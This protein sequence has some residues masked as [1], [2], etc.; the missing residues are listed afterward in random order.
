M[1]MPVSIVMRKSY[2]VDQQ[3]ENIAY[4]YDGN[5]LLIVNF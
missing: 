1:Q 4:N 2:S 5:G 3:R